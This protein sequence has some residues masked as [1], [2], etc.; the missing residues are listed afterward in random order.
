MKSTVSTPAQPRYSPFPVCVSVLCGCKHRARDSGV[1]GP[2]ATRRER[3]GERMAD[4]PG[5]ARRLLEATVSYPCLPGFGR[6]PCLL[7]SPYRLG[8]V[9]NCGDSGNFSGPQ[10]PALRP[11]PMRSEPQAP[12]GSPPRLLCPRHGPESWRLGRA[13]SPCL[14]LSER[15]LHAE[16]PP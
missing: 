4:G 13:P 10:P 5:A 8:H 2:A 14:P 9:W 15:H 1:P 3:R 16:L 7:W 11:C 6:G 12:R